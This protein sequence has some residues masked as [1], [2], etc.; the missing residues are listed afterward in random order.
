[1]Y[2]WEV[3]EQ[4]TEDKT[5]CVIWFAWGTHV[6]VFLIF[7][8]GS[9]WNCRKGDQLRKKSVVWITSMSIAKERPHVDGDEKDQ[10]ISSL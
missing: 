9:A 10:D 2:F 4:M 1:M 6:S 7:S 3:P 5:Y 8:G